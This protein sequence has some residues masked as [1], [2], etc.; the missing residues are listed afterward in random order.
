MELNSE[1]LDIQRAKRASEMASEVSIFLL[2]LGMYKFLADLIPINLPQR[3]CI[4]NRYKY[5]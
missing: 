5:K 4:F 3:F 1:V 2:Q